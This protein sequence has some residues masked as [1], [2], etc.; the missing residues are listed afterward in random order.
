LIKRRLYGI[1]NILQE[2][3]S[4]IEKLTLSK[5]DRTKVEDD[6]TICVRTIDGAVV[7]FGA[8]T[9][10]ID[11]KLP[12]TFEYGKWVQRNAVTCS[13]YRPAATAFLTYNDFA[14]LTDAAEILLQTPNPSG[15]VLKCE[16]LPST[17]ND[18]PNRF[19]LQVRNLDPGC[20]E[21]WF[22]DV[23]G[24]KFPLKVKI[25]GLE[26]NTLPMEA[27]V[28]VE[29][30]LKSIGDIEHIQFH[31]DQARNTLALSASFLDAKN[32]AKA[33]A[34]L[35]T[36]HADIGMLFVKPWITI[37]YNIP[38]RIVT[39]LRPELEQLEHNSRME[40]RVRLKLPFPIDTDKSN[41]SLRIS[42]CSSDAGRLVSTVRVELE[43]LLAVTVIMDADFPLWHPLFA[44]TPALPY[45]TTILHSHRLYIHRDPRKSQLVFYGGA[46]TTQ[47]NA[48]GVLIN[49][50]LDLN[51][52][53]QIWVSSDCLSTGVEFP[54]LRPLG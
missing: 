26:Y 40:H 5:D 42:A 19:K 41:Q 17:P 52:P 23:L 4:E 28:T 1:A 12:P 50:V 35:S 9:Q 51:Q 15:R 45:L 33:V 6:G 32:V 21:D 31:S 48:R 27:K 16:S 25:R 44:T 46:D 22:K 24:S 8:G 54:K 53:R 43:Q 18:R 36:V 11:L 30:L 3:A 2:L 13:W 14:A 49:K 10:V 34:E 29:G 20:Q 39:A 47:E 38:T 37:K 7:T